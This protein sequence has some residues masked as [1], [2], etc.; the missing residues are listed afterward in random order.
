MLLSTCNPVTRLDTCCLSLPTTPRRFIPRSAQRKHS[1]AQRPT[2][3]FVPGSRPVGR[4]FSVCLAVHALF[5]HRIG[6]RDIHPRHK[7]IAP[8]SADRIGFSVEIHGKLPL[9]PSLPVID[10]AAFSLSNSMQGMIRIAA[11]SHPCCLIPFA[12]PRPPALY[13]PRGPSGIGYSLRPGGKRMQSRPLSA[14]AP[15]FIPADMEWEIY[16]EDL[17]CHTACINMHARVLA[18]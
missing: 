8:S 4:S 3:L 2:A 7:Q 17:C 12:A 15:V 13:S 9:V 18:T 5:F 14:I 16:C 10:T 11:A 6:Y 1:L